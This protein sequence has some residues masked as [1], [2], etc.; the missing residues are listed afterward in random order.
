MKKV[1]ILTATVATCFILFYGC[2][3]TAE[4]PIV[5]DL[6]EVEPGPCTTPPLRLW[7]FEQF[8]KWG[9]EPALIAASEE[10]QM[11]NMA[12]F[13]AI[14]FE[15]NPDSQYFGVDG[16]YTNQVNKTSVELKR[17]WNTPSI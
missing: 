1:K 15:N 16:E 7:L 8:V 2:R 3:K 14:H 13:Y 11:S 4:Q 10:L 5:P 9:K 12:N 6:A 17:F